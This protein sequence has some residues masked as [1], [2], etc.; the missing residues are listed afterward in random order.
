MV[1]V[2]VRLSEL[3]AVVAGAAR[4]RKG[5][6][7]GKRRYPAIPGRQAVEEGADAGERLSTGARVP[8]AGYGH[9]E[10]ENGDG[11]AQNS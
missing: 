10:R 6:A 8:L 2:P 3:D 5:R 4:G 7:R 11:L 1:V 9:A